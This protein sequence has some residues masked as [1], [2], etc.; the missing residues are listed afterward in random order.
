[1]RTSTRDDGFTLVETLVALIVFVA[2]YLVIH[3]SLSL[4]WKGVR[5]AHSEEAALRIAQA[6]LAAEGVETP[7]AEG[8]RSDTT[9][10]GFAWTIEVR[11]HD[12]SGKEGTRPPLTGFWVSVEVRWT[13]AQ[14]RR[15]RSLALTTFK[16]ASNP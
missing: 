14:L 15:A 11:R 13:D 2:C 9:G 12:G 16:L 8:T 3:E 7:L 6:R 4:G 5:A 10:E 1:M